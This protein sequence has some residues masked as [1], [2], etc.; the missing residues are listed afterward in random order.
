MT[1]GY[2]GMV[3]RWLTEQAARRQCGG[4]GHVGI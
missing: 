3:N 1:T 2:A 4:R